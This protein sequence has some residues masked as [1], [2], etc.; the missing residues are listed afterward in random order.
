MPNLLSLDYTI[1]RPFQWR[2]LGPVSF[3]GAC[4]AIVLLTVLN[5]AL[6]GYETITVFQS[7]FNVTQSFWYDTFMPYRKPEPGTLCDTRVFN[8]GDAFATTYS[9]FEWKVQSIERPNAGISGVAYNGTTLTDCDVSAVYITGDLRTWSID[10]SAVVSCKSNGKFDIS[11]TTSFTLSSLPGTQ[12][13]LL[14]FSK[15]V[16]SN[17]G[18]GRSIVI[19]A[20]IRK[21]GEDVGERIAAAFNVSSGA[22]PSIVS[23]QAFFEHCPASLGPN[24]DCAVAAP[25]FNITNAAHVVGTVGLVQNNLGSDAPGTPQV[26]NELTTAPINNLLQA[27]YA[28]VRIDLGNDSPNNFILHKEAMARVLN[29]T[30]PV[31]AVTPANPANIGL[32][33]TLVSVWT[34]PSATTRDGSDYSWLLEYLP[35]NVTGASSIQMVYLCQFQQRKSPGSLLISVLVAVLSMFSSGWALYMFGVTSLAKN[36]PDSNFCEG[37]LLNEKL[38]AVSS[39]S[40]E[41]PGHNGTG[42]SNAKA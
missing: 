12:A 1:T 3:V 18:D 23:V 22:T 13:P 34:D 42:F 26:M 25:K 16:N 9:V 17:V 27:I 35:V 11:A 4:I 30:F 8:I 5:V 7:D 32:T 31:T 36:R 29:S 21:A 19:D 14:G 39:Q 38:A 40:Y 6:V 28:S 15:S 24:A 37:H 10:V 20:L 33:S 41:G 2:W